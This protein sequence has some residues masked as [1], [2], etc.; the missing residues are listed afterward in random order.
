[1]LITANQPIGEWNSIFPDVAMTV[2]AVDRLV[3][4]ATTFEMNVE[5]YRRRTAVSDALAQGD[6]LPARRSRRS[7]NQRPA[8]IWPTLNLASDKQTHHPWRAATIGAHPDWRSSHP[9]CRATHEAGSCSGILLIPSN[10]HDT[11]NCYPK[12][13][14]PSDRLDTSRGKNAAQS[15]SATG[16]LDR[17]T[18]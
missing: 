6:R 14:P 2:A 17:F 9:N 4:H 15:N 13:G 12:K 11:N 7:S 16:C 10:R 1:M 18:G 8:T 3:H 5:S